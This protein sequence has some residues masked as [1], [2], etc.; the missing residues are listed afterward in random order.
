MDEARTPAGTTPFPNYLLDT[1]M[2]QLKG[3]EWLVLCV[4]VRQTCGWK[5]NGG[6]RKQ[7]DWITHRQIKE[8]SGLAS[9]S[10]CGAID[11]LVRKSIISVRDVSDNELD[12]AARRRRAGKLL[13]RLPSLGPEAT[14]PF[15]KAKTTKESI[16]IYPFVDF[17]NE[18]APAVGI[19]E[20]ENLE[21]VRDDFALDAVVQAYH[22]KF[23]QHDRKRSAP[24]IHAKD[25]NRLGAII[26]NMGQAQI[27][28][29]LNAFFA[30][31]Y[32]FIVRQN[33]SLSAFT[34]T[35][36]LL[37]KLRQS[38]SAHQGLTIP[39]KGVAVRTDRGQANGG[40]SKRSAES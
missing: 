35:V 18:K 34:H 8:R 4:I 19:S 14:V 3:S 5:Q 17:K 25:L 36:H 26:D 23:R 28:D 6:S 16:D 11:A 13:F 22:E 24:K 38:K 40:S 10:I 1:I 30:S 33:H 37:P 39:G 12:T 20:I 15:Q 27:I 29:L 9:A 7:T 31:D 21:P 2:P 32:R